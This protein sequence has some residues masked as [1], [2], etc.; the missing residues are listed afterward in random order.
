MKSLRNLT[1]ALCCLSL[2]A[3]PLLQ[4]EDFMEFEELVNPDGLGELSPDPWPV[5]I[6]LF[7]LGT[8][9]FEIATAPEGAM[10]FTK[11]PAQDTWRL[12]NIP[13]VNNIIQFAGNPERIAIANTSTPTE[14]ST[15][16]IEWETNLGSG[17]SNLAQGQ[18]PISLALDTLISVRVEW[19]APSR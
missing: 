10:A 8:S 14:P 2:L 16:L 19:V 6:S 11:Q 9:T 18:A 1:L 12:I 15:F 4:A 3:P 17:S 5:A 13:N 7:T